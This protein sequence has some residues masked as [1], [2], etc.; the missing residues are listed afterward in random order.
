M[1]LVHVVGRVDVGVLFPQVECERR[2]AFERHV[3]GMN[4]VRHGEHLAGNLVD[5]R[6][7]VERSGLFAFRKGEAVGAEFEN[8]HGMS[9]RYG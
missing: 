3:V 9:F 6:G 2:V 8:I 4:H 5:E 1:S 7:F